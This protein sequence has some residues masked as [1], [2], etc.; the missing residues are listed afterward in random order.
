[1][2]SVMKG[3]K[4]TRRM[5]SSAAAIVPTAGGAKD[6]TRAGSRGDDRRPPL[7]APVDPVAQ[8][9]RAEPVKAAAP[10]TRAPRGGKPPAVPAVTAPTL[11]GTGRRAADS[12]PRRLATPGGRGSRASRG[13]AAARTGAGSGPQI[14][15][16]LQVGAPAPAAPTYGRQPA[17]PDRA[18]RSDSGSGAQRRR[19]PHRRGGGRAESREAGARTGGGGTDAPKAV[20]P[21]APAPVRSRPSTPGR[22]RAAADRE[23]ITYASQWQQLLAEIGSSPAKSRPGGN[24]PFVITRVAPR[25]PTC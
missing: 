14:R 23:Q 21:A 1:V 19:H 17:E 15:G 22:R 24:G 3:R 8:T 2:S 5:P 25:S 11:P 10:Q 7:R 16:R 4:H 12:R 20:A 18:G 13:S 9:R 6:K